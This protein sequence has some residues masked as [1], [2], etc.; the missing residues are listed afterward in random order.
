MGASDQAGAVP[1]VLHR[2]IC[3]SQQPGKMASL[4]HDPH[5]ADNSATPEGKGTCSGLGALSSGWSDPKDPQEPELLIPHGACWVRTCRHCAGKTCVGSA[6]GRGQTRVWA[7]VGACARMR[8]TGVYCRG[9]RQR[10][11]AAEKE[12]KL[13]KKILESR[14][15]AYSLFEASFSS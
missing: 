5:S 3:P 9:N 14:L 2:L 6:G 11:L 8:R 12:R 1:N 4:C 10:R 15:R 7:W 13:L